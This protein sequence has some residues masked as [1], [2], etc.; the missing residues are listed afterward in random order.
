MGTESAA[1]MLAIQMIVYEA[2]VAIGWWK[3][4]SGWFHH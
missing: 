3:L 2:N 1:S 4:K